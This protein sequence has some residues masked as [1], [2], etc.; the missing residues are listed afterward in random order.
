MI[1]E[2]WKQIQELHLKQG[3]HHPGSTFC[4]MEAV[5]YVAGEDWTDHPRG[6]PPTMATYFRWWNDHLQTD[7]DRDR[8]LKT[9]I[10]RVIGLPMNETTETRRFVMIGDW[11]LRKLIPEILRLHKLNDVAA[12]LENKPESTTLE[13][14]KK[15]ALDLALN[16]AL[17]RASALDLDLAR[18]RAI[19]L[20][21]ALDRALA[22]ARAL[23]LDLA[24]DR[25][26]DLD[27]ARA[28]FKNLEASQSA[29]VE[30]LIDCRAENVAPGDL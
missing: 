23:D 12:K 8:L 2:R 25:A 15:A 28:L 27:L 21:L 24:L 16:R 9:F 5:A 18:A 14:F 1:E 29:L 22:R 19:D 30:R 6:V 3:A 20:A 7:E 17:D 13:E 4:V 26:L 10:P 11:I